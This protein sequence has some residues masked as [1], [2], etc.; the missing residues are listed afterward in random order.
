M[1]IDDLIILSIDDHT[2]EP[3]D[4]FEHHLPA[5]YRDRAPRLVSD[6]SGKEHWEFEGK[7]FG[8]SGLNATVSWPKE[9]WGLNPSALAEMRPA[10]YLID[11]RIRDM[12][13]NGV[14]ASMCFPSLPGFSGRRFQEAADKDLAA[15]MLQA[16]NDWHI[17][18]WCASYPGRFM[19]LS[20]GPA[21]DMDALVAEVK[22]VAAKGSVAISMPELPHIQGLP[23]YQS[24]YWDPF[25][26]AVCDEGLVMCLHIGMGL[27]AIDM[28][29]DFAPDNFMVLST[30]VTVLA[31]QDLL[32]GPA[33]RKYPDLKIAFS[34]GGIGWIP[35]LMDRVDRHYVNQ[36]WTGQDFG[37]KM[38]SDVFREH[39]L[40][41]FI[42]DPTSLKLFDE[43]GIDLI[44]FECDYPHSDS[45][46][47]DAPEILL[48][49][50]NGAGLS[51]EDIEKISWR[52]VARFCDYDPFAVLPKEQATVGALRALATDVDTSTVSRDEWRARYEANP[53]YQ[54]AAP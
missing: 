35:F 30:Q 25:F 46:W 32:W 47:P 9:E 16:Y 14:L 31:V 2:V 23:T 3:P 5:K 37:D 22:R 19:P 10:T 8:I 4:L 7:E 40:A 52:N 51:D 24:E 39:A 48:E 34:E 41:C 36:R 20:I 38:P 53:T 54:L 42:Y 45:L 43:I 6:E 28:G 13:R 12:N 44:A 27:D 26:R 50:C 33:M 29:P 1:N 21:W 15:V 49:Q 17:D 18:E 11:E